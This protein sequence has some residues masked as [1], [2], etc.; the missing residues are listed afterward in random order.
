MI[1]TDVFISI[2]V[3]LVGLYANMI[4]ETIIGIYRYDFLFYG[5]VLIIAWAFAVII[6]AFGPVFY[7]TPMGLVMSAVVVFIIA[8]VWDYLRWSMTDWGLHPAQPLWQKEG[9]N[10]ERSTT[11]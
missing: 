2:A 8:T 6:S 10:D 3:L 4:F 11:D 1:H 5:I 9:V 7:N